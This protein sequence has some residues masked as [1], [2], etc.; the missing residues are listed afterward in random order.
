MRRPVISGVLEKK[1]HP[2][3]RLSGEAPM[4]HSDPDPPSPPGPAPPVGQPL[5]CLSQKRGKDLKELIS[6]APGGRR[7]FGGL[8]SPKRCGFPSTNALTLLPPLQKMA[9]SNQRNRQWVS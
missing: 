2:M 8:I 5:G 1:A 9:Q 7:A 6:G 3:A 4:M